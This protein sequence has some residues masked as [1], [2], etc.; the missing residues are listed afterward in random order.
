MRTLVRG[1][2][3]GTRVVS[4][5]SCL[6]LILVSLA[7]L[8]VR[9]FGQS[10]PSQAVRPIP[11]GSK[12]P[13]PDRTKADGARS[14][15]LYRT[16]CMDCHETDG[17]GGSSREVMRKIPDFT[18]PEWHSAYDDDHLQHSIREGKGLMPAMKNQLGPTE[19]VHLV[20]LVRNF[21]GGGQVV[22]DEP[23]DQQ[24]P[25]T[26]PRLRGPAEPTR[27]VPRSEA[28]PGLFQRLCSS[29]HE[30]DGHGN[31]MRAEIPWFPDFTS[32]NWH[33]PRSDAQLTASILEGKGTVMPAFSGKIGEP[34]VRELV[35]YLRSFAPAGARSIPTKPPS[36]FR[37][38]YQ[39]LQD[40]MNKLKRQYRALSRS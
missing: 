31:A 16:H 20:S 11:G 23:A 28:I 38:R 10:T 33:Q 9:S 7:A 21:R 13:R 24:E 3:P 25:S 15:D 39:E 8:A 6:L 18:K 2:V 30:A 1:T 27:P 35:A 34:Q 17:R 29:C 14:I 19:V 12:S 40:E 26:Q 32:A 22:P 5:R 4:G 36:D 37:R